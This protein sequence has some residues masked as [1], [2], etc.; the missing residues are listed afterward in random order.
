MLPEG[1]KL[2]AKVSHPHTSLSPDIRARIGATKS[3]GGDTG[4]ATGGSKLQH[5]A[6]KVRRDREIHPAK[7]EKW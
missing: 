2:E 3:E 6:L 4:V 5:L 7:M 1:H